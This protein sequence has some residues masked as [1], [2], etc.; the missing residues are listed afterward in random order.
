[1][2][3]SLAQKAGQLNAIYKRLGLFIRYSKQGRPYYLIPLTW[4]AHSTAEFQDRAEEIVKQVRLFQQERLKERPSILLLSQADDL[5]AAELLWRLGGYKV[6]LAGQLSELQDIRGRFDLAVLPQD[7]VSF[8][9]RLPQHL[10]GIR[11]KK[12]EIFN[13]CRY[14]TAKLYDLLN[15][16]GRLVIMAPRTIEPTGQRATVTFRRSNELKNFLLFSHVFKTQKRY[17][18]PGESGQLEVD[19]YDLFNFVSQEMVSRKTLERLTKGRPLAELSPARIDKLAHLDLKPKAHPFPQQQAFWSQ[20]FKPF[21]KDRLFTPVRLPQTA[22]LWAESIDLSG[23]LPETEIIF[24][25]DK[26]RPEVSLKEIEAAADRLGLKGCPVALLANYKDSFDYLLDVL[27]TLARIKA[28]RPPKMTPLEWAQIRMPF[29]LRRTDY[30]FFKDVPELIRAAPKLARLKKDL[31][32]FNLEGP[33]TPV[34]TNLEKLSLLGFKPELLREMFLILTGHS[35]MSRITLGKLRTT[36]LRTLTQALAGRDQTEMVNT[37]LAARLM[38]L[39]EVAALKKEGLPPAQTAEFFSLSDKVIRVA[40]NPELD[41]SDLEEDQLSRAGEA[42]KPAI[43]RMLKL[44]GLFEHLDDWPDLLPLGPHEKESLAGYDQDRLTRIE[45]TLELVSQVRAFIEKFAG[46]PLPDRLDFARH[47]LEQEFHGTTRLLPALGPAQGISLLWAVV[48]ISPTNKINFNP[49]LSDLPEELWAN[50]VARLRQ[51]LPE[52]KMEALSPDYLAALAAEIKPNQPVFVYDSGLTLSLDSRLDTLSVSFVDIDRDIKRLNNMAALAET[53][54]VSDLTRS[55]LVIMNRLFSHLD[56]Y[57]SFM[58]LEPIRRRNKRRGEKELFP[59]RNKKIGLLGPRLKE[60]LSRRLF[61]PEALYDHLARLQEQAPRLLALLVPE[62]AEM[63]RLPPITANYPGQN[64]LFFFLEAAYKL[65]SLASGLVETFQDEQLLHRLAVKEF[66]PRAAGGIG[67]S[68]AQKD[69]LQRIVGRLKKKRFLLRAMAVALTFQDVARLPSYR[70][71]FEKETDFSSHGPAGASLLRSSA[72]LDR[73]SLSP[74][75]KKTAIWLVERHGLLGRVVWGEVLPQALSKVTDQGDEDLFDAFFI[76]NLVALAAFKPEALTEDLLNHLLAL[77]SQALA[78]IK[79]QAD[80]VE[81]MLQE[82]RKK[83]DRL[84][85]LVLDEKP[86]D[87]L[88]LVP[89]GSCHGLDKPDPQG[90]PGR[91]LAGMERLYRLRGLWFLNFESAALFKLKRPLKYIHRRLGLASLG[92]ASLERALYQ[93]LRLEKQGLA[94]APAE[95]CSYLLSRLADTDRPVSLLGYSQVSDRLNPINRLKLALAGLK[96]AD[97]LIGDKAKEVTVNF[98]ELAEII[99]DRYEFINEAL[100]GLEMNAL[101]NDPGAIKALLKPSQGIKVRPGPTGQSVTLL[102][103]DPFQPED[104]RAEA[105]SLNDTEKLAQAFY[106]RLRKLRL[107]PHNTHVYELALEAIFEERLKKIVADLTEATLG[108]L[109]TAADLEEL[110]KIR[111]EL[112]DEPAAFHFNQSQRQLIDNAFE[113]HQERLRRQ[114]ADEMSQK[115]KKVKTLSELEEMWRQSKFDL[116]TRRRLIGRE[117]ERRISRWF[118]LKA[119]ELSGRPS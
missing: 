13:L 67:V 92:P 49:L 78:V 31:N 19:L 82:R 77:R 38:S 42:T 98:H 106:N 25:G 5:L 65:Q 72:I 39:A 114:L 102:F 37:V 101:L 96:A 12:K 58:A 80:W 46:P 60:V 79:G 10:E 30:G 53:Q 4:L 111:Q 61:E 16:N 117:L 64:M 112:I 1:S 66:G 83:Q 59:V 52:L 11:L 108:R 34:L 7:V 93:A 43:R 23:P 21:F 44:F 84:D 17:H 116:L 26:R 8:V 104:F 63:D 115:L 56:D 109:Q 81:L 18:P 3:A 47:F 55:D 6:T 97:Y 14:L 24:V 54:T 105:A 110:A 2:P 36:S 103:L 51:V 107:S 113:V 94:A 33:R 62:L 119:A 32:P 90:A 91:A 35:T 87:P 57:A 41:W 99:D 45:A 29:D 100:A 20:L 40:S 71:R 27:D 15:D 48:N 95:V 28:D 118:D 9:R 70:Q 85:K 73:Y 68:P 50:R 88:A 74:R 86:G 89:G 69:Q 76:H 22:A 75:A